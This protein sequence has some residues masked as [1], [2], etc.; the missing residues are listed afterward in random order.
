MIEDKAS[1]IESLRKEYMVLSAELSEKGRRKWAGLQAAKLGHGGMGV[2]RAATGMDYKTIA[3]GMGE[4]ESAATSASIRKAGGGRKSLSERLP[5]IREALEASVESGTLGDPEK[6]LKWT[7]KS[8][9]HL[10]EAIKELGY[11]VSATSVRNLLIEIGYTLQSNRKTKDGGNHPDRNAQFEFVNEKTKAFQG[12]GDPVISVDTKK[13]ELI[14]NFKNPGREYHKKGQAPEV[15]VHDFVD[16]EKGKAA[17]YGIYDLNR[18][19]GWV[20]VGISC[21]TAEFAVNSIRSWW[22]EMGSLHYEGSG[23]IYVNADGGGSNGRRNRLWKKELQKFADETR[24]EIHVSHF[25]PG[26]S[27][28]N[29]IEHRMFCF[30]SQNWRGRPLVDTATIVSLIGSTKTKAGLQIKATLDE[31]T[32]QKGIK[33][34][35]QELAK[36]NLEKADFHGE[37]NYIIRPN[38]ALN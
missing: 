18:N 10:R 36:L 2:V 28:W 19:D 17:P 5:G 26:T 13:K 37:W 7:S 11:E 21:D 14:G 25:P 6:P 32:Y 16:P 30:I 31:R 20:S 3:R 24:K 22:R 12:R 27:K 4:A 15:N 1:A 9:P 23:A 38:V 8:V 34:S 33:V 29:K 35:D